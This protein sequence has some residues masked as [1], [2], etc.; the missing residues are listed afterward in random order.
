MTT[1]NR[2]DFVR[3]GS[4]F[5]GS[6]VLGVGANGCSNQSQGAPAGSAATETAGFKPNAWLIV[7]PDEKATIFVNKSEMGQGV[8]TGMPTIVADE[9][10]IPMEN[11]LIEFAPAAA[12]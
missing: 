7:H 1:I 10:D 5:A 12:V 11:V 6:L 3:L 4:M 8:A 2:A 9:L